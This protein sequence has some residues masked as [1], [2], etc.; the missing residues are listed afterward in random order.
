MLPHHNHVAVGRQ[1]AGGDARASRRL[2]GE[3]PK[4]GPRAALLDAHLRP[5]DPPREDRVADLPLARSERRAAALDLD[6]HH[7]VAA[8]LV[9][10]VEDDEVDRRA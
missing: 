4:R 10:A 2:S 1:A 9:E 6:Q 7:A 5:L 3:P 8:P